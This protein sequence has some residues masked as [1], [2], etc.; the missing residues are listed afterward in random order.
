MWDRLLRGEIPSGQFSDY[1][2]NAIYNV[3]SEEIAEKCKDILVS[4]GTG[5][6]KNCSIFR[7][8]DEKLTEFNRR[9]I[10]QELMKRQP[11]AGTQG[12]KVS[13]FTQMC[14][15]RHE[16]NK[17]KQH[18]PLRQLFRRAGEAIM[19]IKPCWMMSPLAVAKFLEPGHLK[20]DL[21]VMDEASQIRPEDALGTLL[22]GDKAVIVG[23]PKQLPPTSFFQKTG[24]GTMDSDEEEPDERS[25]LGENESIL[26]TMSNWLPKRML[27]WHYRSRHESLIA[28][29]NEHFY[30]SKLII[31]PSPTISS[32]DLGLRFTYIPDGEFD[33]GI[34]RH[35]AEKVVDAIIDHARR[36]PNE[37]LAVVTMNA[38]Q[39][40]LIVGNELN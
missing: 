3:L 29:S 40:T 6:E 8:K 36:Y 34:N 23:D 26:D 13:S 10:A 24:Y 32:D 27:H 33:K 37:S 35:E 15:V 18:L 11:P 31:F 12:S 22:R 2:Y 25:I 20:F 21:I 16:I 4:T 5:S 39:Q 14:L 28:F 17:K 38:G 9:F 19:E 7:D 30:D 1:V